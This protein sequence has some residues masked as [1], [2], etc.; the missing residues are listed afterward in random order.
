MLQEGERKGKQLNC[1]LLYI[2]LT[3]TITNH[4]RRRCAYA[5]V[6]REEEQK[7][8]LYACH[9]HLT[10]GHM[11]RVKTLHRIKESFMWRRMY[12]DVQ[13]LVSLS[14]LQHLYPLSSLIPFTLQ[15]RRCDVCQHMNKKLTTGTP[16]LHPIPVKSPSYMIGIDYV[17]PISPT[18]E[19]GSQY[20]LSVANYFT[21]FCEAFPTISSL[22]SMTAVQPGMSLPIQK[23][24]LLQFCLAKTKSSCSSTKQ[25]VTLQRGSSNC[26]L[27]AL[28]FAA[29]LCAGENPSEINYSTS[30]TN[31]AS[32]LQ[33]ASSSRPSPLSHGHQKKGSCCHH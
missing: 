5:N 13:E 2:T 31:Y 3:I 19:D 24:R 27:F 9:V 32:T 22:Q 29:L 25:S 8:I 6:Q 33:A 23:S 10:A 17:S 20:I 1:I 12:R 30:S 7:K 15:L 4:C 16:Q 18:A 11:G 28:V 21:K 14:S 26:V